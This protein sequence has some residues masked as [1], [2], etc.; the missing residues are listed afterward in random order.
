MAL[1]QPVLTGVVAPV[2]ECCLVAPRVPVGALDDAS[3][4]A[5]H[6]ADNVADFSVPLKHQPGAGGNWARFGNGVDQ[7]AAIRDALTS[8]AAAFRV[9]YVDGVASDTSFRVVTDV[10]RVVGSNGER[11]I[12]VVVGNDG[13]IGT[14]S[15][16]K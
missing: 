10:G 5:F 7:Q 4:A 1:G 6:A 8:D 15:P 12:R 13:R 11:S 9:N 16:V 3:T 14:A 2:E